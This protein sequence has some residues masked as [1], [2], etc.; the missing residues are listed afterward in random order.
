[1]TE[2]MIR[3]LGYLCL[4]SRLKRLGEQLQ[5]GVQ[6]ASAGSGACRLT[7]WRVN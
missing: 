5:T 3:E 2:D 1:M 4:G 6:N 7:V